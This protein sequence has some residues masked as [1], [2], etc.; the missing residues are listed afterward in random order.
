MGRGAGRGR[1]NFHLLLPDFVTKRE[2][3]LGLLVLRVRSL[4][5]IDL[6]G[7]IPGSPGTM[8]PYNPGTD[9]GKSL[10]KKLP[11]RILHD[12]EKAGIAEIAR[13]RGVSLPSL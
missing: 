4:K 2:T 5:L 12:V 3:G 10:K 13:S 6:S 9:T 1:A 8:V 11:D 7:C